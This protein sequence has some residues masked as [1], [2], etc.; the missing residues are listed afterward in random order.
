M[1]PE[2]PENGLERFWNKL[3]RD[4]LVPLG[5]LATCGALMYATYHMRKGNRDSFQSAL[6]WRVV[7]QGVTVAAAAISLYLYRPVPRGVDGNPV[8]WNQETYERNA[9]LQQEEWRERYAVARSNREAEDAAIRRMVEKEVAAR[10]EQ[11]AREKHS[12]ASAD[13]PEQLAPEKVT[14]SAI[15]ARLGQDK[16]RFTFS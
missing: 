4:P 5:S 7:F 13:A 3:K 11:D 2:I 9:A 15:L 16:R 12:S 8:H 1:D 6:R 10:E 14:G